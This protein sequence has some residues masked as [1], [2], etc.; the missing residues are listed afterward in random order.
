MSFAHLILY[1]LVFEVSALSISIPEPDR[2]FVSF[3]IDG[4]VKLVH[5]IS[6]HA[7]GQL[8][9]VILRSN[10]ICDWVSTAP[11]SHRVFWCIVSSI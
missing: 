5:L 9:I 2:L 7:C 6:V 11:R 10:F 8:T 3:R 4:V 1:E